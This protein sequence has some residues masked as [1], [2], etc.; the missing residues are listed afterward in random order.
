M[1]KSSERIPAQAALLVIHNCTVREFTEV[2][3]HMIVLTYAKRLMY[4]HKLNKSLYVR[5]HKKSA[6]DN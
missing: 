3:I 1:F 5:A 2:Y 4:L 6:E